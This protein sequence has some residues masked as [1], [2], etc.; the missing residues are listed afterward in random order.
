LAA[1]AVKSF[2]EAQRMYLCLCKG[3]TM[4]DFSEIVARHQNC[5]QAAKSAMGLDESCCGR[6]ERKLE[7]MIRQVSASLLND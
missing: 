4:N 3:I 5:P 2:K 1:W 6:C 7:S